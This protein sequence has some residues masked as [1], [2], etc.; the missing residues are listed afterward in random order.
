[1]G[2]PAVRERAELGIGPIPAPSPSALMSNLGEAHI[3]CDGH[4]FG[5]IGERRETMAIRR[6]V[7]CSLQGSLGNLFLAE[8]RT[9]A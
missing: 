1:M 2:M 8:D 5:S 6:H 4:S 3:F 7:V 9:N